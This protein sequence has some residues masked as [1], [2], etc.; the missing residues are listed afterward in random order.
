MSHTILFDGA[1]SIDSAGDDAPLAFMVDALRRRLDQP[2]FITLV[3]HP[4]WPLAK[5]LGFETRPNLEHDS[6]SAARGRWFQGLNYQDDRGALAEIADTIAE[7]NLLVL[8]AGNFLTEVGIDVLRGHLP[9]FTAMTL[10]AQMAGTPVLLFGLSANRLRHPWTCRAAEWLLRSATHVSFR[11]PL[12]IA[13]LEA[14]GV[15]LPAYDLLPDPAIGAPTAPIGTAERILAGERIPN[16]P[17]TRRLA[18]APRDLSWMGSSVAED[19][20]R[21]Q[22]EVIDRWCADPDREVLIIPQC[23]YD[24]DGPRTDDRHLGRT[25]RE[26]ASHPDRVH[27]VSGRYDYDEI[28]SLYGMAEVALATRLHGAVFAAR[29]GTPVIGLAYE[30]KVP[31]FFDQL[32]EP[33]LCLPLSTSAAELIDHLDAAAQQRSAVG[34]RLEQSIARLQSEVD[35]YADIAARLARHGS[36]RLGDQTSMADTARTR[37]LRRTAMAGNVI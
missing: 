34:K 21:R 33:S 20:E 26:R 2:R 10:A 30:D 14:S 22:V 7:A 9:R 18:I 3:R 32:G 11:E 15:R 8:G 35:R 1:Y 4:E 16:P 27:V 13:N 24:V 29:M 12:G 19:Y 28:E 31:G 5:R 37:P 23:T 17:G 6:A 25:F 36:S